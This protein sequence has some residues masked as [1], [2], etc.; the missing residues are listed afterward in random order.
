MLLKVKERGTV[1]KEHKFTKLRKY[2]MAEKEDEH[3]QGVYITC[4]REMNVAMYHITF[5]ET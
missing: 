4:D 3:G 2:G 1:F 5:L